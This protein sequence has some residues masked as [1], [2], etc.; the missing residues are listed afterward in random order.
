MKMRSTF[1]LSILTLSTAVIPPS[2]FSTDCN[3]VV[4]Q[5]STT[6]EAPTAFT[7]DTCHR[8]TEYA[9]PWGTDF[10]LQW[11]CEFDAA[12]NSTKPY[13]YVYFDTECRIGES[14]YN[15]Y[16][17]VIEYQCNSTA[18]CPSTTLQSATVD[19]SSLQPPLT[20]V[21]YNESVINAMTM[22]GDSVIDM[23]AVNVC[24]GNGTV[25]TCE[26]GV[27]Y[28]WRYVDAECT[29]FDQ[30]A[31][32]QRN[33]IDCSDSLQYPYGTKREI[34]QC[35]MHNVS[36]PFA[37]PSPTQ[38]TAAPSTSP[39]PTV[40]PTASTTDSEE[41]TA[42]WFSLMVN[43]AIWCTFSVFVILS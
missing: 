27:L 26:D 24:N 33:S 15:E 31:V 23:Y 40:T 42:N 8:R 28:E 18:Q 12:T 22:T 6:N 39:A 17:I 43:I 32:R 38:T 2:D 11:K 1:L 10:S 16:S 20:D 7:I 13:H 29:Q 41:S 9:D 3:Y 19:C 25:L 36:D 21:T 34:T 5:S 4:A 14:L 30:Y 37:T 35:L